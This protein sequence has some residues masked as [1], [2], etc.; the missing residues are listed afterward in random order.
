MPH[1]FEWSTNGVVCFVIFTD[2]TKEI[3]WRRTRFSSDSNSMELGRRKVEGEPVPAAPADAPEA[4]P[5]VPPEATEPKQTTP[6]PKSHAIRDGAAS[7]AVAVLRLRTQLRTAKISK[8]RSNLRR[9]LKSKRKTSA[10]RP[11][12]RMNRSPFPA[13]AVKKSAGQSSSSRKRPV[14]NTRNSLPQRKAT[15]C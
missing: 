4:L 1:S 14:S 9:G 2:K 12:F 3:G 5:M 13:S 11:V 8:M 10:P 6:P 15:I 7:A